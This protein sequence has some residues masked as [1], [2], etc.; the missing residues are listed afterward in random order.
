MSC[1]PKSTFAGGSG[2]SSPVCPVSITV[3]EPSSFVTI[4]LLTHFFR[5]KSNIFGLFATVIV[6]T[7]SF[8]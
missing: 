7:P 3:C 5:L 2:F 4:A 6:T 8:I 1:L